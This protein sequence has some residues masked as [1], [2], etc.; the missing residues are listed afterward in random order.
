MSGPHRGALEGLMQQ[1]TAVMAW[2]NA[3]IRASFAAASNAGFLGGP[4]DSCTLDSSLLS[5]QPLTTILICSAT[6]QV[7]ASRQ[8]SK[9]MITAS[10]RDEPSLRPPCCKTR[11][12]SPNCCC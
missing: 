1:G 8:G 9:H 10:A 6:I 3:G 4:S 11:C 2:W 7:Q 12:R 5:A